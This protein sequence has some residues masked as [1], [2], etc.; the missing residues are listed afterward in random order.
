MNI[1]FNTLKK[2]LL[3][4]TV[5]L[6]AF[7]TKAQTITVGTGTATNG[8]TTVTPY[9]TLWEDGRSQFLIL[10]SE[11]LAAGAPAG[12]NINNLAFNV[13]ATNAQ[14]L[15]GFTIKI[16]ATSVT[17]L[18]ATFQANGGFTTCYSANIG[19]TSAGWNTY[20]FTNQFLWNGS[21]NIIVEV[22]YDN[23]AWSGNSTVQVSTTSFNSNTSSYTDG[24]TGCV[25]TNNMSV[26]TIRPNI[27]M[28]LT[29]SAPCTAP[30]TGGTAT[31]SSTN[32]CP[33]DAVSFF[34]TGGT[35]GS[36]ATYQWQTST[37]TINW[38]NI[39][40]GGTS[41]IYTTTVTSPRYFRRQV[42][43]STQTAMSSHILA[44][45]KQ[46]FQCYCAAA[47]AYTGDSD[48][49]KV[50]L[51]LGCKTILENGF[52]SPATFNNNATGMFSDFTTTVPA[53][54]LVKGFSHDFELYY[55]SFGNYYQAHFNVFIDYNRNGAF[56]AN[57]R[58]ANVAGRPAGAGNKAQP[59]L[60][61]FTVPL[62]AD[63]GYTGMRI[64]MQ[65]GGNNASGPCGTFT[66][67]GEVEDYMIRI[68]NSP[69]VSVS[70]LVTPVNN[71]CG[72]DPTKVIVQV[73]NNS[74][75]DTSFYTTART[76][77]TGSSNITLNG[78]ICRPILPGGVDTIEFPVT[79]NTIAGGV[80][81]FRAYP[82][83]LSDPNFNNDT[84]SSSV[85]ISPLPATPTVIKGSSFT[86]T[87]DQGTIA[88]PDYVASNDTIFYDL[89]PPI[90]FDNST[91]G[92]VWSA[93]ITVKT[94]TGTNISNATLIPPSGGNNAKVRIVPL[95]SEV[96][97]MYEFSTRFYFIPS[98]CD[99]TVK[100]MVYVAPRPVS[101]FEN[102]ISCFGT[103]TQFTDSTTL[104]RGTV[105]YAWDFG[106]AGAA[107][108]SVEQNPSYLFS[109]PGS[110]TVTLTTTSNLGYKNTFT[111][112]IQVGY[113]PVPSYTYTNQCDGSPF[114]FKNTSTIGGT[115][116]TMTYTWDFLNDNTSA[117]TTDASK[118][119]SGVG[120]YDVK[121]TAKSV[122][123]CQASITKTVNV[124][125]VPN[126]DFSAGDA[127]TDKLT[128]LNNTST[129]QYGN[130]GAYWTLGNGSNS[131]EKNPAVEYTTPGTKS[132][133]LVITTEFGCIDSITKTI[134]VGV[135]PATSFI[136]QAVCAG[137]SVVFSNTT[138]GTGTIN[139]TWNFGDGNTLSSNSST[140]RN[141]YANSGSYT[142][143]LNAASGSCQKSVTKTVDVHPSPEA[144]FSTSG[145]ACFGAQTQ[146]NN[147]SSGSGLGSVWHFGVANATSTNTNPSYTYSSAGTF[148][149]KLVVT[150]DKGCA[151]SLTQQVIVYALPNSSFSK[152]YNTAPTSTMSRQRQ[153]IL[154]PAD[155]NY[156]SYFWN[157][158]DGTEY[159]Q[160]KP[161]HNYL[162]DGKYYIT[163]KVVDNRGC[164]NNFL[165]SAIFNLASVAGLNATNNSV[166]VY[167]NPFKNS[168]NISFVVA[169]KSHVSVKV[170]DMLG[171][172]V[173]ALLDE[174]KESGLHTLE[175]NTSQITHRSSGYIIRV[176]IDGKSYTKQVV[177]IK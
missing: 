147:S 55:V 54:R 167:P 48:M 109:G 115:Q 65:E 47:P 94:Y 49:G 21:S 63:T 120:S 177:E 85:T 117:T 82:N 144:D 112:L 128:N 161:V 162:Q 175:F 98:N 4:V 1:G 88:Q 44:T 142:V 173:K 37:D 93:A 139:S 135:T 14:A 136:A 50:K 166:S 72:A 104:V 133:K 20:T 159:N 145:N 64:H 8:G 92:S 81:N 31:A 146:F 99:T 143:T 148:D 150:N 119:Y 134:N 77:I 130:L 140:V 103:A 110:Y 106:D 102:T 125:P 132:V 154:T 41:S 100:R 113:T 171:R 71:Q 68:V 114:S 26:G 76:V 5:S 118:T 97:S 70:S 7:A 53:A 46:F 52:D 42:T 151:D 56:E 69:D 51:S 66:S 29:P 79:L 123:N 22:C 45:P 33:A 58:V 38:N 17:A 122:L 80:Y 28:N 27:R 9:K 129:V 172:E 87:F 105:T 96:D 156:F 6:V 30:P 121:L 89:T 40:V 59:G 126:A 43:C 153:V 116:T 74:T 24:V 170:Y 78:A 2:I 75:T 3:M 34:V 149:V 107:D 165:D 137:D 39:T 160:V 158:G 141:F 19:A 111:K 127:C 90:G 101:K 84:T 157:M 138:T 91:Y 15:N 11:L 35:V 60:V 36:G 25:M 13:T 168:T 62:T 155:S 163:L 10:A 152:V 131:T 12:G 23:A 174:T 67:W 73:K 61:S 57:E 176:T 32:P 83:H 86:G 95:P 164:E 16:G 108:T 124:F 18:T 169:G